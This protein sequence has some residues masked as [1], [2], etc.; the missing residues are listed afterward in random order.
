MIRV[1][2]IGYGR[3]GTA[4][5][6]VIRARPDVSLEWIVRRSTASNA[7]THDE[8]FFSIHDVSATDLLGAH[9]VDAI[10]DFS[11]ESGLDYY[12]QA[13]A[14]H[15]AAVV[16]AISAFGHDMTSVLDT[17]SSRIPL[18]WS[19]NITLG[20]NFVLLAA[21]ALRQ[22]SPCADVEIV[23]EH[24]KQKAEVSGTAVRIAE[25]LGIAREEIKSLRAGGIVG[26]HEVLFG[27]PFQTVRLRHDSISRAA[28]GDGAV[29]AAQH[30]V[31]RAAGRYRMED[32]LL[33]FFQ[34]VGGSFVEDPLTGGHR[35]GR[36]ARDQLLW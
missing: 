24:F 32:L 20:I 15:G 8:S 7:S 23:E 2:L 3:T 13:A 18:L 17:L 27:F 36:Q 31:G 19:P 5:A 6:D 33:P 1:G 10:I 26:S 34:H 29:F 21:Q 4:V 30:L 22:I 12:G 11:S 16:C 25:A 9:P 28:F 35:L 14:D